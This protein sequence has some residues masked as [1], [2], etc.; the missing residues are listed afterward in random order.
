MLTDSQKVKIR[1]YL[2]YMDLYR[3]ANPRLESAF[4]AISPEAE[5]EVGNILAQ[6][7][8]IDLRLST[9]GRD[10]AGLTSV[11]QGD[12]EFAAGQALKD[13][14]SEGNR[15]V[16]QLVNMFGVEPINGGAYGGAGTGSPFPGFFY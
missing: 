9:T 1:L 15:Y 3:Y 8:D 12:P 16:K 5:T 7:A 13:L 14:R 2:G 10:L 6:L 4:V 11:G